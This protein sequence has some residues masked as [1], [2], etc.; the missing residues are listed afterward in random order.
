MYTIKF[1]AR[2]AS[3]KSVWRLRNEEASNKSNS[4]VKKYL[5]KNEIKIESDALTVRFLRRFP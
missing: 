2:D 3:C 5:V 4:R 1:V